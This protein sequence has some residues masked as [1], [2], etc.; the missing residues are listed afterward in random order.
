MVLYKSKSLRKESRI[1]E[2]E[3]QVSELEK[4]LAKKDEF[5][6]N[7]TAKV[8][9]EVESLKSKCKQISSRPRKEVTKFV[10]K[11]RK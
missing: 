7:I 9:K 11:E 2:L 8:I 6:K 1:E 10:K 5:I 4:E 3:K